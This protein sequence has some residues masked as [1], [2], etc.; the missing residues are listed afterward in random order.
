[1]LGVEHQTGY[2]FFWHSGKLVGEDV[3][4]GDQPQHCLFRHFFR[5]RIGNTVE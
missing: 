3:L 5:Q 4:K 2:V 1:M